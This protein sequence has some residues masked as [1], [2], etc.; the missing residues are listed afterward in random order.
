MQPLGIGDGPPE[1]PVFKLRYDM[2]V[3]ARPLGDDG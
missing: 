3:L 1:Q 2:D